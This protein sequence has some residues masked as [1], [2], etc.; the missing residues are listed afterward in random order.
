MSRTAVGSGASDRDGRLTAGLFGR[1][2]TTS[3]G[4][5]DSAF[6][7][8]VRTMGQTYTSER[9][10]RLRRPARVSKVDLD[11]T[12]ISSSAA[13]V[14]EPS[15]AGSSTSKSPTAV[16]LVCVPWRRG[17]VELIWA[18]AFPEIVC[19]SQSPPASGGTLG[20]WSLLSRS[21]PTAL[22]PPDEAD[23]N[24][25]YD[26]YYADG[27]NP[28]HSRSGHCDVTDGHLA[29]K[30]AHLAHVLPARIPP[31]TKRGRGF[32]SLER[33]RD[34][35]SRGKR[36]SRRPWRNQPRGARL[37]RTSGKAQAP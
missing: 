26:H 14:S 3:L 32:R 6:G 4:R 2:C 8:P 21:R 27:E 9:N 13:D 15:A 24:S 37:N 31:L 33:A 18:E 34:G 17:P 10:S 16:I 35:R 28:A 20:P 19:I 36:Q 7:R 1:E 11:R 12:M 29:H 5:F 25:D 22:V 30:V 23:Q